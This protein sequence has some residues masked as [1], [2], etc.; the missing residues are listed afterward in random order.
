MSAIGGEQPLL[1]GYPCCL[2]PDAGDR[3]GE[4]GPIAYPVRRGRLD[5]RLH[6]VNK[7]GVV[8]SKRLRN[9]LADHVNVDASAIQN[10]LEVGRIGVRNVHRDGHSQSRACR[11]CGT[12]ANVRRERWRMSRGR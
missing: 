4:L 2:R 10:A 6:L 12:S 1:P 9:R 5:V 8:V 11:A 7:R 3:V